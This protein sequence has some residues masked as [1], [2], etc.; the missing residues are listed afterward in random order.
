M[1]LST[2]VYL[3]IA[4]K[5]PF[6][7]G[8]LVPFSQITLLPSMHHIGK[9]FQRISSKEVKCQPAACLTTASPIERVI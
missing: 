8:G 3:C 9:A 2:L 7:P 5:C 4:L 1:S 6:A